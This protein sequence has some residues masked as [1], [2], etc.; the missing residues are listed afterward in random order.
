MRSPIGRSAGLAGAGAAVLARKAK[1]PRR[2]FIWTT[3][4]LL[5]LSFVP[6]ATFGFD[7]VSAVTLMGLHVL[8]AVIVIPTL[9]RRL[10]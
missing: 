3:L 7:P 2:T 1:Q 5:V 4:T 8:A 10:A 9:A 6:D